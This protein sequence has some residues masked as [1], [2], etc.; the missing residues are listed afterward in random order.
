[1]ALASSTAQCA[2]AAHPTLRV[3]DRGGMPYC[4]NCV[5]EAVQA[6]GYNLALRVIQDRQ[7][8]EDALQEALLSAY[9]SFT[10]FRG[11]NL[12]G[13]ML[14]IVANAAKDALRSGRAR[15]AVSLEAMTLDPHDP[16]SPAVEFPSREES[17]D[18]Y[19]LRREVGAAVQDGLSRL[20]SDQKMAVTLVD[21]QGMSYEEA[22][23][24]MG[25]SLGTTKSRISRGRAGMRDFLR[26][27]G[28]LLP[29]RLRQDV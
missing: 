1:M 6:Q 17:P 8:A 24:I 16:D 7:L 25:C 27:Q 2:S 15:P 21:I 28:E 19:A 12:S 20:S 18:D 4:F 23:Q 3:E 9:R 5:I 14:R 29:E 13:W 11:D 22:S 26:T 10:Q